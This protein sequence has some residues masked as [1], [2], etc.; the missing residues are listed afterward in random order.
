MPGVDVMT[1]IACKLEFTDNTLMREHYKSDFHRF[2][3]KRK[4]AGLPSV[5]QVLFDEKVACM[6]LFE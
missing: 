2:N 6:L 5:N 4:S 3:L 1:C